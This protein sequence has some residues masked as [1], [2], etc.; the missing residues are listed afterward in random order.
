MTLSQLNRISGLLLRAIQRAASDY[1]ARMFRHALSCIRK[2]TAALKRGDES[3]AH[4]L[5]RW[6]Y[7]SVRMALGK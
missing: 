5:A 2:A 4:R 3:E 7:G 1:A 6:A